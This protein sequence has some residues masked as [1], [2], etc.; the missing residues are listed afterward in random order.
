MSRRRGPA[1]RKTAGRSGRGG[2]GIKSGSGGIGGS[3]EKPGRSVPAGRGAPAYPGGFSARDG[4]SGFL[5]ADFS[6]RDGF[7]AREGFPAYL[8]DCP[9][10]LTSLYRESWLA[11]RII[12][13]PSEDMTRSW[14]TLSPGPPAEDL[15]ALERLEARHD[16]RREITAAIRWARLY[17]GACALMVL[18][19]QED[20]LDEPLDMERIAP[21]DFRGLLVRDR[22]DGVEPGLET[23]TDLDDPDFGL[24]MYYSFRTGDGALLRVHHSRVLRFTGRDLPGAQEEAARYWGASELEH[25]CEELEKRSATSANIA[26]L[27]F[28]A[29]VTTLKMSDFGEMLALGTEGQRRQVLEAVAEQNRM[30]TSFGLQLLSAGDTYENHPYSFAG[31]SEIYEAFMMDMAGAAGIPATRLFGRSPQGMNATGESDL[32]NY[33]ELIGQMRER[34]LRPALEKLLPVMA[35]S[36][37]G[38]VPEQMKIQ[39]PS[40]MPVSPGEEAEI[41]ARGADTLIRALQAGLLTPAEARSRLLELL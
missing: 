22:V 28:Q 21:G 36:C 41:R 8:T 18:R 34:H 20:R 9:A 29:N 3:A 13:M 33:Y 2:I 1:P 30:R 26:R 32:K 31:L 6:A 14:Y 16:I 25:I 5:P 15:E 39:F 7:P 24:P 17:G 19:G 37:W 4:F 12:D 10:L 35:L 23:E 38:F 11:K 27:V 40:L